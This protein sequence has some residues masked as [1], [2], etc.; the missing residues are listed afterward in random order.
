MKTP[1]EIEEAARQLYENDRKLTATL[2]CVMPGWDELAPQMQ[3]DYIRQ[4]KVLPVEE[5]AK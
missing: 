2:R 4:V 3:V 5:V 1:H